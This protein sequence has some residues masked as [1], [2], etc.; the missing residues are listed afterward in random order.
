MPVSPSSAAFLKVSRGKRPVSSIS[1]ACGFTS[2]SANSL[3][4]RCR[5]CCSSVRSR[6][7]P[8]PPA[9]FRDFRNTNSRLRSDN[10]EAKIRL[11]WVLLAYSRI[12]GG[13]SWH[14][15]R[16]RARQKTHA[17][18]AKILIENVRIDDKESNGTTQGCA[19]KDC[20]Q[21]LQSTT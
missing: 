14:G 20:D 18:I 2:A 11:R 17:E 13:S 7:T 5:S 15:I 12:G 10:K 19:D 16:L 1:F 9:K 3:T 4:L 21:G 6:F 8:L